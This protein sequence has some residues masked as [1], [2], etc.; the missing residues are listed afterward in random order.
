M[1]WRVAHIRLSAQLNSPV[2]S[3]KCKAHV[4]RFRP[5]FGVV[6]VFSCRRTQDDWRHTRYRWETNTYWRY[7]IWI[8]QSAR[9]RAHEDGAQSNAVVHINRIVRF[10]FFSTLCRKH[11]K[12][13]S[14]DVI[15]CLRRNWRRLTRIKSTFLHHKIRLEPGAG[16]MVECTHSQ[17]RKLTISNLWSMCVCGGNGRN[18]YIFPLFRIVT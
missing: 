3:P 10:S 7:V 2:T 13:I 5:K 11:L 17:A 8:W 4:C 9:A 12:S 14:V 16:C 15:F 1:L 18:R 6:S